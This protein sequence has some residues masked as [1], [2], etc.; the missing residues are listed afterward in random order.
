MEV[1]MGVLVSLLVQ[2]AKTYFGTDGWKTMA[3]SVGVSLAAAAVY[4]F[5]QAAGYWEV[6]AHVFIVASAFYAVIIQRFE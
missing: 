5:L 1:I 3:L 6:V 2:W 4:V